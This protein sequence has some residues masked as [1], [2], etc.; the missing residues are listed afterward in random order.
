MIV[1]LGK[2]IKCGKKYF[3][4]EAYRFGVNSYL[5]FYNNMPDEEYIKKEYTLCRLVSR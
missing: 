3:A 4:D 2:I 1:Q 5:G